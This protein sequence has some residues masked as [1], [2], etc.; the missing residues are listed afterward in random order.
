MQDRA[1]Q[2]ALGIAFALGLASCDLVFGVRFEPT[3]DASVI[4]VIEVPACWDESVLGDEDGDAK[5]N[6]CD[7]CP[8]HENPAQDDADRDGVGDLCDPD[9][10]RRHGIA[11][12]DP[13]E[14]IDS[15]AWVEA[16]AQ[17]QWD[18]AGGGFKQDTS[19]IGA[20]LLLHEPL[21]FTEPTLFV[22][23]A[24]STQD[25]TTPIDAIVAV[26]AYL[27]APLAE[28]GQADPPGALCGT[29]YRD[30]LQRA[31]MR[32]EGNTADEPIPTGAAAN[33]LLRVS[34]EGGRPSCRILTAD[35]RDVITTTNLSIISVDMR[36]GLWTSYSSAIFTSALVITP[37]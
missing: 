34:L 13:L 27:V 1:V 7:N 11:F 22:R 20:S 30:G 17:T 26:G 35:G 12:F 31:W 19:G 23:V 15:G 14:Q 21:Q 8:L 6:G 37:R 36:I 28:P 2:R 32:F 25:A 10:T 24:S 4:D 18:Y 9:N 29:R 3:V 5:V 33:R 16:G